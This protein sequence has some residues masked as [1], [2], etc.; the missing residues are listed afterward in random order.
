MFLHL[1]LLLVA[2]VA[3]VV[4]VVAVVAVAGGA[5]AA[6]DQ[7]DLCLWHR[8]REDRLVYRSSIGTT[9]AGASLARA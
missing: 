3:A 6:V 5:V 4:A 1:L 7:P 2:A 8:R 9:T